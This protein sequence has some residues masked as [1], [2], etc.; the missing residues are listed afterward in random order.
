MTKVTRAHLVIRH[1]ALE[2]IGCCLC[3][4]IAPEYFEMDANGM[5]QLNGGQ[6]EGVFFRAVGL[7]MDATELEEA[8]ESCPVGII[9]VSTR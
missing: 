7:K 9:R 3:A 5:A 2:C 6:P 4:E 1:K 8:E